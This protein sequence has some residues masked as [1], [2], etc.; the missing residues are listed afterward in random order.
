MSIIEHKTGF[1]LIQKVERK[2]AL[3]A[4]QAMIWQHKP[5]RKKWHTITSDDGK[6]FAG[7][8]EGARKLKANLYFAYPLFVI[9]AW[10]ERERKWIDT[11]VLPK[12]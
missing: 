4:S 7:H 2:I 3:A 12:K 1:T 9:G 6:E 11:A 5:H 8:E 10:P